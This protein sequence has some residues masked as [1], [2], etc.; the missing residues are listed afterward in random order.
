SDPTT[1]LGFLGH[2]KRQRIGQV[3]CSRPFSR[4]LKIPW[5]SGPTST[6]HSRVSRLQSFD[7]DC[8]PSA[9][10]RCAS[11]SISSS[12]ASRCAGVAARVDSRSC[13]R[14]PAQVAFHRSADPARSVIF[15]LPLRL[16]DG[17]EL[18][19]VGLV[20]WAT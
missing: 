20:L 14:A 1:L 9:P 13:F 16:Q 5:P 4:G 10:A 15:A 17:F 11:S 8:F 3:L 12:H 18:L 7:E 2:G 19:D 6:A